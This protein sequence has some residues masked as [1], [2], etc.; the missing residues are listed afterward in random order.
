MSS[1]RCIALYDVTDDANSLLNYRRDVCIPEQ[2]YNY[3]YGDLLAMTFSPS[4]KTLALAGDGIVFFIDV[5][6]GTFGGWASSY[7]FF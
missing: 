1:N 6:G 3:C 7:F 4:G 5:I 2:F